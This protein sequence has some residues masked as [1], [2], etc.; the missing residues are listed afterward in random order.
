MQLNAIKKSHGNV[1]NHA[2]TNGHL[3]KKLRGRLRTVDHVSRRDKVL[4]APMI[5]LK[6]SL[7]VLALS[8]ECP[9]DEDGISRVPF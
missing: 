3:F 7:A 9:F 6:R 8:G 2:H 4:D 1:Q 5:L